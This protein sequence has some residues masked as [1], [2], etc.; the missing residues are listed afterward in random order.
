MVENDDVGLLEASGSVFGLLVTVVT[1]AEHLVPPG[2][3]CWS[4]SAISTFGDSGEL[5]V[6]V[7][8]EVGVLVTVGLICG[9]LVAVVL[10]IEHIVPPGTVLSSISTI[11]TMGMLEMVLGFILDGVG[12][13]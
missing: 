10:D 12:V 4:I 9:S 8:D 3:A 2:T 13:Y 5:S 11:V 1:E 6:A 7:L